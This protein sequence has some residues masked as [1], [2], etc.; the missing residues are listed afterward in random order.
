MMSQIEHGKFDECICIII[1]MKPENVRGS[2]DQRGY[3]GGFFTTLS[4]LE[5]T[6]EIQSVQ[7]TSKHEVKNRTH[8]SR[9]LRITK[10]QAYTPSTSIFCEVLSSSQIQ[11][12]RLDINLS[13]RVFK[14]VPEKQPMSWTIIWKTVTSSGGLQTKFNYASFYPRNHPVYFLAVRLMESLFPHQGLNLDP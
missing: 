13:Q 8:V 14:S 10:E 9:A 11:F 12:Q 3:F 5:S 6:N 4:F 7:L 1:K 2:Q